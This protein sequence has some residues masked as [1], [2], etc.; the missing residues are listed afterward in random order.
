MHPGRQNL[1]WHETTLG[2]RSLCL[3]LGFIFS[4]CTGCSIQ[5]TRCSME[6]PQIWKVP[7]LFLCGLDINMKY[8]L[9]NCLI[10]LAP[11]WRVTQPGDTGPAP[12]L[13]HEA[14]IWRTRTK[15]QVIIN[16]LWLKYR[17]FISRPEYLDA[18]RAG[19]SLSRGATR[20]KAVNIYSLKVRDDE[21]R[22]FL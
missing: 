3:V 18:T 7:C 21:V 8:E 14:G 10:C 1:I 4:F 2:R 12:A 6:E 9:E 17:E 11:S 19:G 20:D 5:A 15:M 13:C 16:T 22:M